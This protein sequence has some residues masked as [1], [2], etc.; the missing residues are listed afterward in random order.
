MVCA[1]QINN[2]GGERTDT[3]LNMATMFEILKNK[4]K[5][6]LNCLIL[7][8]RSFAQT[9]KN[10]FALSFI[11]KDGRVRI[12]VEANGSIIVCKWN[13]KQHKFHLSHTHTHISV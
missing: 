5:V 11:A 12:A 3:D 1:Q 8:R 10:L 7:N 9:V 2:E 4:K 6:D 13:R